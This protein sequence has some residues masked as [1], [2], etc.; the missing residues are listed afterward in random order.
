[1]KKKI[2]G[3][4]VCMLMFVAVSSVTG[5]SEMDKN[6]NATLNQWPVVQTLDPWDL[7]AVHDIG[8]TGQTGANGNSGAEFDG[9]YHYS[10]RWAA[11]LI[12]KYDIDGNL[13]DEFSIPGVSGLRDLAWDGTYMYGGA[14][15][16]TIWQ[17]NFETYELVDTI[18]GSFE[19]RAIAYN[20][21]EDVFYCSN[22]GDP[23]WIVDRDGGI[24]DSFNLGDTT[25]TYGFAY[26]DD[27]NGPYLWVFDQTSGAESTIYQ[28]DLTAG[29][30]TGF[31]KDVNADVGSGAGIAGGLWLAPDYQDGLMCIGGC[32]QDSSAPGVTDW[33][34]V[35]ELYTTNAPPLTPSTPTGPSEGVVEQDYD[36][37][38]STTDPDEDDIQYG[39]DFDGDFVVDEWTS[40]VSSGTASTVS[41]SYDEPGT[42]SIRVRARDV[43]D[44]ESSWS[45]PH[46]IV[47]TELPNLKVIDI[48]GT[49][50]RVKPR[51]TNNGP[52][53]ADG[54]SW[55]ITFDGGLIIAGGGSGTI[56]MPSGQDL[57]LDSGFVLGIGSTTI[58]V[59]LDHPLSTAFKQRNAFVLGFFIF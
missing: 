55:S 59:S 58:K 33:L 26:D 5:T 9:T 40:F 17:M 51:I 24:V 36:F 12:H 21:D 39:W 8:A 48:P 3:V 13:V 30:F 25:S 38:A 18:S 56:D 50:F 46:S 42:Y 34:F 2:V 49:L 22:W 7:L 43:N 4:I 32:V 35:Y 19:S 11:N 54:V 44:L 15:G 53:D 41:T 37:T 16:S 1:M 23:V 10:T 57:E 20:H 52:V 14:A 29:A 31:S 45:S 6:Q 47:I 27:E 28:W